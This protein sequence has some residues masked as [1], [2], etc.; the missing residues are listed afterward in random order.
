MV[1]NSVLE[2]P[3]KEQ[4]VNDAYYLSHQDFKEKYPNYFLKSF[5]YPELLN[6]VTYK[7]DF[8]KNINYLKY[9]DS[10]IK[11][12]TKENNYYGMK[13]VL[14]EMIKDQSESKQSSQTRITLNQKTITVRQT[15]KKDNQLLSVRES[16][17]AELMDEDLQFYYFFQKMVKMFILGEDEQIE[18]YYCFSDEK[19]SEVNK[20]SILI[21]NKQTEMFLEYLQKL[22]PYVSKKIFQSVLVSVIKNIDETTTINDNNFFPINFLLL[23][24]DDDDDIYGQWQWQQQQQQ[25]PNLLTIFEASRLDKNQYQLCYQYY[26]ELQLIRIRY[27]QDQNEQVLK[28]NE[29]RL[30]Q[31][32]INRRYFLPTIKTQYG[33]YNVTY[34]NQQTV[35]LDKNNQSFGFFSCEENDN[36]LRQ[37]AAKNNQGMIYFSPDQFDDNREYFLGLAI[38]KLVNNKDSMTKQFLSNRIE[39]DYFLSCLNP[40]N[41]KY[42][43]AENENRERILM[44]EPIYESFQDTL[45][46]RTDGN[47]LLDV[48]NFLFRI[49]QFLNNYE[50]VLDEMID[51][52]KNLSIN[53]E[54]EDFVPQSLPNFDQPRQKNNYQFDGK[55]D[56]Q[57]IDLVRQFVPKNIDQ[58][59]LFTR[60]LFQQNNHH[61]MFFVGYKLEKD[62]N[63][64]TVHLNKIKQELQTLLINMKKYVIDQ[65]KMFDKYSSLSFSKNLFN[66]YKNKM[67]NIRN[68][69]SFKIRQEKRV[70]QICMKKIQQQYNFQTITQQEFDSLWSEQQKI[71]EEN[72]NGQFQTKIKGQSKLVE[73]VQHSTNQQ[74]FDRIKNID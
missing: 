74:K 36:L 8:R 2:K 11:E 40:K 41:I 45:I 15:K 35:H 44:N 32:Y 16:D 71:E 68:Q 1:D 28:Q 47:D 23:S 4:I 58:N 69:I 9:G 73:A 54:D 64:D 50:K 18:N 21:Q 46:N 61:S 26:Y 52:I 60:N 65:K 24:D 33:S 72:I 12:G 31:R 17:L 43:I 29:Q 70:Y 62:Y 25:Y 34:E 59:D 6:H 37:A 49:N 53:S 57:S 3:K 51:Q 20:D 38:E 19:N 56:D 14:W 55:M 27:Q 39:N 7:K 42:S 66:V 13:K 63:I 22:F 10:E 5:N 48:T 30:N 67:K